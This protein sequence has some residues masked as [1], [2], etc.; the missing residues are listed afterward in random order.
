MNLLK[1]LLERFL[2]FHGYMKTESDIVTVCKHYKEELLKLLQDPFVEIP[3]TFGLSG[4][5]STFVA[6]TIWKSIHEPV[7][8]ADFDRRLG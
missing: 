5:N 6:N 4:S 8:I 3:L 7:H 1:A 2:R